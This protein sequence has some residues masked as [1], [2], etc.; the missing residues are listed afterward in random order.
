MV[1]SLHDIS[2][3][4]LRVDVWSEERAVLHPGDV[5]VLGR[6][7]LLIDAEQVG[8]QGGMQTQGVEFVLG[9]Y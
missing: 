2:I 7:Q 9:E 6:V 4:L 8:L 1:I 3:E 5:D